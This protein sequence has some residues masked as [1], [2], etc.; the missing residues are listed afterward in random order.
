MK[1]FAFT[2]KEE[3]FTIKNRG[4]NGSRYTRTDVETYLKLK[5]EIG[6]TNTDQKVLQ[7]Q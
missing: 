2:A 1:S 4:S 5:L 7:Y 3:I 6:L